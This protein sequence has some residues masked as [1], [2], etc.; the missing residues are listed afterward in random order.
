MMLKNLGV[1]LFG[2]R[3]QRML[4][5]FYKTAAKINSLEPKFSQYTDEQILQETNNFKQ[6]IA[7]GETLDQLLPEAFALVREASKR[8]LGLR[9]YDVQ[10]IGG[11]ILHSGRIVEMCTGEG[12]T[13]SATLPA[14]LNALM[15]KGV[16][17]VTVNPYL[18]E[19]DAD[20]MRPIYT[21]L[22]MSVG[23]IVPDMEQADRK[24]AYAADI[25]YATNNEI[26]FFNWPLT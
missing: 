19:R 25:T 11:M 26:G 7:A 20:W 2:S 18:V 13:L 24:A 10:L 12:K 5:G 14:Y 17:V 22:G 3:N 21:A 15:G 23:T 4:K 9:H 1:Q 16:H 6:R 8:T